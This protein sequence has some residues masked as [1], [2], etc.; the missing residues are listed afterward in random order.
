MC[1]SLRIL[2]NVKSLAVAKVRSHA[3]QSL[4]AVAWYVVPGMVDFLGDLGDG[5]L[6]AILAVMLNRVVGV[7]CGCDCDGGEMEDVGEFREC[8]AGWMR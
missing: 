7:G 1:A 3:L 5:G 6:S 2:W 8:W 4:L